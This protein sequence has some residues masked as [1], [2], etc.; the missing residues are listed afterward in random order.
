MSKYKIVFVRHGESEWNR[1]NLFTG[2]YDCDLSAIG[3]GEAQKAGK[4][5]KGT[6]SRSHFPL[7]SHFW[8]YFSKLKVGSK[9][10]L[11]EASF[12]NQVSMY[13]M[14]FL[15]A[16]IR[17]D[18]AYTSVLSRAN[19][20]CHEILHILGQKDIPIH[21][22]WK[23]NERHYGDL[24]GQSKKE[25]V[26][27]FGAEQV[28]LW[29]RSYSTAPPPIS[30][31]NPYYN[32]IRKVH[33]RNCNFLHEFC[34]R[35]HGLRTFR[36]RSFRIPNRLKWLLKIAHCHIGRLWSSR[37]LNPGK[38]CLSPRMEIYYAD[39]SNISTI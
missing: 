14:L 11:R 3:R 13:L 24:T 2:W 36:K 27:E 34:F 32:R 31:K 33:T 38:P 1:L 39:S 10:T 22:S 17:F 12:V 29:R 15:E 8:L 30:K 25:A 21:Y 37:R 7:V 23:L 6:S 35:I 20:T 4:S 18:E 16:G 9:I 5:I 19:Q 26:I 28:L